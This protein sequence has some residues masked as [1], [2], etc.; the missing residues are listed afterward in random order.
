MAT[1][2]PAAP[3]KPLSFR[4]PEKPVEHKKKRNRPGQRTNLVAVDEAVVHIE[5]LD[6]G[7]VVNMPIDTV[8]DIAQHNSEDELQKAIFDFSTPSEKN[9]VSEKP[10]K[11][12]VLDPHLTQRPFHD[13]R[14]M[15]LKNTLQRPSSK[16]R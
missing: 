6:G 10:K 11:P 13:D 7:M 3:S 4:P 1:P 9:P 2:K 16:N 12:F 15:Q 8:E 5:N 14:L